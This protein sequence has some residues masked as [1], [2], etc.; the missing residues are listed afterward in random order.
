MTDTAKRMG[1]VS[2][3]NLHLTLYRARDDPDLE[4]RFVNKFDKASGGY[5]LPHKQVCFFRSTSMYMN[6]Q[7]NYDH[8]YFQR[9]IK[10]DSKMN[11]EVFGER[12]NI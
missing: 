8:E 2:N 6:M 5:G 7:W 1:I 3:S 11:P 9:M 10:R 12:I 4:V